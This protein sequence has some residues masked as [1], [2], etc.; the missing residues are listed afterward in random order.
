MD[1]AAFV[2]Y[3][4]RIHVPTPLRIAVGRLGTF[5]FPA[6]DYVYTGSAK[7]N[8]QAR[9]DRHLRKE[10]P[11]RWH[12]DYL[13]SAHGVRVVDVLGSV[14]AECRLNRATPGRVLITAFGASDCRAGCGSH[15][16]YLWPDARQDA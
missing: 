9:I 5:D 12:I 8:F 15:L 1:A 13:L 16:K 14:E 10:K 2:T 6:G 7:R 3:Q 4:L 11:F